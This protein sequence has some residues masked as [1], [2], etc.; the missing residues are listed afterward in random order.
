MNGTSGWKA[1]RECKLIQKG[2]GTSAISWTEAKDVQLVQEL[3]LT[4]PHWIT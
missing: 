3:G 2:L 1:E 4:D